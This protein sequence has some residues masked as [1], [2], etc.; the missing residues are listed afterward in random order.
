M[1]PHL[2]GRMRE[3]GRDLVQ[4][5][6]VFKSHGTRHTVVK[7]ASVRLVPM[8]PAVISLVGCAVPIAKLPERNELNQ[9]AHPLTDETNGRFPEI[10]L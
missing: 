8:V 2:I 6:A 1:Q 5:T 10:S 9:N 3:Y 4:E 7:R